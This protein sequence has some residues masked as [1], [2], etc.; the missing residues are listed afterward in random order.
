MGSLFQLFI[1]NTV[2]SLKITGGWEK[3]KGSDGWILGDIP[4]TFSSLHTLGG[5][6]SSITIELLY[7]SPQ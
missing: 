3:A 2:A 1:L 7:G 6:S 5:I 4:T